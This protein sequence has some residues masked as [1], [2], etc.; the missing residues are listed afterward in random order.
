MI[1]ENIPRDPVPRG[2]ATLAVGDSVRT[3]RPSGY[4]T[5]RSAAA[6]AQQD[7]AW[8]AARPLQKPDTAVFN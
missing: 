5:V 3:F 6:R 1:L 7:V 8:A 2:G 4:G